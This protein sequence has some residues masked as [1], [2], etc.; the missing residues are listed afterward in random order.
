MKL[1]TRKRSTLVALVVGLGVTAG[2]IAYA[3]IPD[4]NG[5]IQGC[6]QKTSGALRVIDT[7]GKG[8]TGSEKPLSWGRTGPPGTNGANGVSGYELVWHEEL[9]QAPFGTDPVNVGSV[10]MCPSGKFATGGGGEVSFFS[11]DL[12][13]GRGPI[14]STLP[15]TTSDPMFAADGWEIRPVLPALAGA[16]QMKVSAYAVCITAS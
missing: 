8:C 10:A 2:G 16:N 14:Q 1:W 4:S 13:I 12:F 11:D 5:L 3:S 6:Y 15:D 9:Y 7:G